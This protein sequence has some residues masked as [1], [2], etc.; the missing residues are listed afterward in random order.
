[1]LS[2]PPEI[3][4]LI[5]LYVVTST[6]VVDIWGVASA[7]FDLTILR[8]CKQFHYEGG[9]IFYRHN[10]FEVGSLAQ[11]Q[12]L[13]ALAGHHLAEVR[14]I[15][16]GHVVATT[17]HQV[18]RTGK[19][20]DLI[21][22]VAAVTDLLPSLQRIDLIL[23]VTSV[24]AHFTSRTPP[25]DCLSLQRCYDKIF[26]DLAAVDHAIDT[27]E[28]QQLGLRETRTPGVCSRSLT[29]QFYAS[30][31]LHLILRKWIGY[32]VTALAHD[33]SESSVIEGVQ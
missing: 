14:H 9:Q 8:T 10:T 29:M 7:G 23:T 13:R 28:I 19:G 16:L 24:C 6:E 1:M 2:L 31:G 15:R 33:R 27:A 4:Q 11:A 30:S 17:R 26:R 5:L 20:Q 21:D 32:L 12:Q 22:G 25:A 18:T 3:R